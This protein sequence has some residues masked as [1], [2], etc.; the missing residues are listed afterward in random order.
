MIEAFRSVADA[1][2]QNII[3]DGRYWYY[4]DGLWVTI[5]I[6]LGAC[7]LGVIIGLIIAII[8]VLAGES[9]SF[10]L[11]AGDALCRVY[12]AVIRGT[13]VMVQLLIFAFVVFGT[14]PLDRIWVA[15][16]ALGINSGAYV[17]ETIRAGILAVDKG[18]SEAGRSLGLNTFDTYRFIILPQALK[19][20]LPPLGN[21]VIMLLKETAI[22][23]AIAIND[24]TRAYSKI[25]NQTYEFFIPLFTIALM[26]FVIVMLMNMGLK[27]LERW[28]RKS[29]NR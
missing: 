15:I 6:T 16:I 22:V 25:S 20:V 26:Y 17:S 27:Y 21:E 3:Y 23:S 1:L 19:N 11:R 24:L 9:R 28:L 2:Y 13:P 5:R 8:R 29:D 4:I 18:Q 14:S 10:F 12:L 7:L